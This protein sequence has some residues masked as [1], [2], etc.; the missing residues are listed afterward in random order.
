MMPRFKPLNYQ[1]NSMVVI[2]YLDQLQAGTFEYIMY[3]LVCREFA[4]IAVVSTLC[5][6]KAVF[7]DSTYA[8]FRLIRPVVFDNKWQEQN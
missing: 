6:K 3:H 8:T 4:L 5:V 7:S 1:Q 2:N